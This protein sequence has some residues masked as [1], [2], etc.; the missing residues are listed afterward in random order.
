RSFL[1]S[2][3]FFRR[4]LGASGKRTEKKREEQQKS[5]AADGEFEI[6]P[7]VEGSL[8]DVGCGVKGGVK[9]CMSM[10]NRGENVTETNCLFRGQLGGKRRAIPERQGAIG[11]ASF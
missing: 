1:G 10:S 2:F 9:P 6:L 4:S 5:D 7:G 8:E 3:S 11:R